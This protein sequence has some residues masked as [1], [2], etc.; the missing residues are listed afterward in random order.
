MANTAP[1][2]PSMKQARQS[3]PLRRLLLG[4]DF[5]DILTAAG[6]FEVQEAQP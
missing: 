2:S 1:A 3:A 4:A 5:S 6:I